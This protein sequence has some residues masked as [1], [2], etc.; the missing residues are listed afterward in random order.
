MRDVSLP[1]FYLDFG[2]NPVF[3][4]VFIFSRYSRGSIP[5]EYLE[6]WKSCSLIKNLLFN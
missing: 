1:F 6:F 4:N 5:L 2:K 3:L